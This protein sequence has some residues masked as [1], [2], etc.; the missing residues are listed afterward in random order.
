MNPIHAYIMTFGL[1]IIPAC[2][3]VVPLLYNIYFVSKNYCY[4]DYSMI[5][6]E[7]SKIHCVK[8]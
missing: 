4:P 5:I 7:P 1:L 2:N 6:I 3:T 8:V